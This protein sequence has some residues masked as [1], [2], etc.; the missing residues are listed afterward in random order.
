MSAPIFGGRQVPRNSA[1]IEKL[2]D[3]IMARIERKDRNE[4]TLTNADLIDEVWDLIERD[5]RSGWGLVVRLIERTD[6]ADHNALAYI[7]AGPLQHLI[8]HHSNK[9]IK[10]LEQYALQQP[11]LKEALNSVIFD[12]SSTEPGVVRRLSAIAPDIRLFQGPP[13]R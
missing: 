13:E 10:K 11:N 6:P 5:S 3:A 2:C 1:E 8:A 4:D 12:P 9:I 7:G